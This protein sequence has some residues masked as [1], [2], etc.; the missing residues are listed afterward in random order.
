MVDIHLVDSCLVLDILSVVDI[1]VQGH[2]L[3]TDLVLVGLHLRHILELPHI[4]DIHRMDS[5]DKDQ[6]RS[7]EIER[8]DCEGKEHLWVGCEEK[9]L[10]GVVGKEQE[11]CCFE[12]LEDKGAEKLEEQK[13]E[14]RWEDPH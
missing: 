14:Q 2:P 1:L 5:L 13:T 6:V 9:V 11:M 12:M 4:L 10:H 8:E 3:D 7:E